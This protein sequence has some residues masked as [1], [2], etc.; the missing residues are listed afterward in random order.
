MRCC[1]SCSLT[2]SRT[3][4]ARSILYFGFHRLPLSRIG[5]VTPSSDDRSLPPCPLLDST[6]DGLAVYLMVS[7]TRLISPL[8][9]TRNKGLAALRSSLCNTPL[10]KIGRASCRERVCQYV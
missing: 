7:S 8:P 10:L 2:C 5:I 6:M 9:P 1:L 4:T 3:A